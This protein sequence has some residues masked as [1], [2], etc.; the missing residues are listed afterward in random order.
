LFVHIDVDL[1]QPTLAALEY[2]YPRLA[3]GGIIVCDDY[4][5][6]SFPGAYKA[7]EEFS[8]KYNEPILRFT[9]CQAVII[10]EAFKS[11]SEH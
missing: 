6:L 2:F 4:G 11:L 7:V 9:T 10:K 1:Y 3:A 5:S 8:R